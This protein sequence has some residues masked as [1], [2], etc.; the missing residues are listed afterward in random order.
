[1][2]NYISANLAW[3]AKRRGIRVA[4]VG[5]ETP[6]RDY[7]RGLMFLIVNAIDVVCP[8]SWPDR[9][10]L[11]GV[12]FD[13]ARMYVAGAPKFDAG[14]PAAARLDGV[15]Q[16]A[17]IDERQ[18]ILLGGSIALGEEEA[19]LDVYLDVKSRMPQ[20]ALILAP[21]TMANVP[22]MVEQVERRG[23]AAV[24]RSRLEGSQ[25]RS[26]PIPRTNGAAVL[27][28]D[29]LGE[30]RALYAHATVVFVGRSMSKP[31]GA[32][33]MEPAAYGKPIVVG[34]YCHDFAAELQAFLAADA[35]RQVADADHLRAA[36][37]DLLSD[38]AARDEYGRR[39]RDV[40][41]QQSGALRRTVEYLDTE[42][43]W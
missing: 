26:Q 4:L 2:N 39:A 36:I 13:P 37:A 25:G 16:L 31:G 35:I 17:G 42:G 9:D 19:L 41:A 33:L 22:A 11:V 12:G 7:P 6:P 29:T 34:P 27:V 24:L 15:L 38:A 23:L 3:F 1:V 20:L 8:R 40:V 18:P 5:A 21:R 32:N 14:V 10:A 30:L 28:L 43:L